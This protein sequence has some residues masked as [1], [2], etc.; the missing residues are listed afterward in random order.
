MSLMCTVLFFFFFFFFFKQKTAYEMRISDWSSDVCSSDLLDLAR[1]SLRRD[2]TRFVTE[3]RRHQ[4][5][6]LLAMAVDGRQ[7][8]A[9]RCRVGRLATRG[10]GLEELPEAGADI[11]HQTESHRGVPHDLL[12]VAVHVAA[13]RRGNGEGITRQPG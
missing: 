7:P 5:V 1:R 8:L 10:R 2:R 6:P 3:A 9:A 11:G 4:G 12:R 13:L